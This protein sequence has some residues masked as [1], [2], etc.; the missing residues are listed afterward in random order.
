MNLFDLNNDGLV[1]RIR[2]PSI[3]HNIPFIPIY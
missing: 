2:N 1:V 3:S